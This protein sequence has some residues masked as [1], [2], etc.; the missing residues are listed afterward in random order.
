MFSEPVADVEEQVQINYQYVEAHVPPRKI[1]TKRSRRIVKIWKTYGLL[2]LAALTP[3]LFSIPIGTFFMTRY[4]K[5]R[6]KIFLYMFVSI[7]IW[8]LI[9][10][11]VLQ[12]THVKSLHEIIK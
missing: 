7:T 3:V 6:N 1:F 10:T 8:S 5:N 2:G 9:L 12:L 11:T 4:E